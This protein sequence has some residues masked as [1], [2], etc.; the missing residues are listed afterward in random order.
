MGV[1]LKDLVK[2]QFIELNELTGKRL[3]VDA[4]NWLYQF[5]SIIRQPDGTPLMDKQGRVTSHLAGLFYR[6]ANLIELGIMPCYVFDGKPPQFKSVAALR[7]K[8]KEAASINYEEALSR[9]DL[10]KARSFASQT[11]RLTSEMI[12]ESKKLL[13]AMGV[14]VIEAPSEGEAQVA[15]M[16]RQG[17]FYAGASQD[18]DSLLFGSPMVVRNLNLTGKRKIPGRDEYLFIKPEIIELSKVLIELGINQDQLIMLGV[19][20]GTDYNPGGIKGVGPKTA[21]KLVRE[22]KDESVFDQVDWNFEI[23]PA[24]IIKFFKEPPVIKDYKLLWSELKQ[25]KISGLLTAHDFSESRINNTIERI[26]K[27]NKEKPQSQLKK[28]F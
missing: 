27:S 6:T 23:K 11:S 4:F 8:R 21:L 13:I 15:F 9:G 28:W 3:G 19:L 17:D 14:P 7:S 12:E 26:N 22:F 24:D 20:I 1:S 16:V 18:Y 2:P 10:S 5:L 25:D